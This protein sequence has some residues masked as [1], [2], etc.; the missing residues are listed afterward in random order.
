MA[1]R[2]R[3]RLVCKQWRD[4]IDRRAPEQHARTRVLVFNSEWGSSSRAVVFDLNDGSRR[5]EWTFPCSSRRSR[6]FLVGT[7][8][9][10]LCLHESLTSDK[11]SRFSTT[12][13]VSVTNPITGETTVLPPVPTSWE[14]EQLREQQYSFG[15]HPITGQYKV[16]HIPCLQNQAVIRA[17]Q[18]FTLGDDASSWRNL[19]VLD[20]GVSY[21]GSC[22]VVSVDG[23]TYWLT[24]CSDRVM[25]L[26]LRDERVT[27]FRALA[28]TGP[29]AAYGDAHWMLTNIHAGLGLVLWNAAIGWVKVWVLEDREQQPRWRQIY[30]LTNRGR[31][32][33]DMA[34]HLTYGEY[35]LSPSW[36]FSKTPYFCWVRLYCL[37]VGNLTRCD[38]EGRRLQPS[39]WEELIMRAE[40]SRGG[41]DT[42]PFVET[43]ETLPILSTLR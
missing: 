1:D 31:S 10:L 38:S 4:I 36:E 22:R 6:V 14:P 25:A 42:F 2:R 37:K 5:H 34:P 35:I 27:S 26:D 17:V 18:V 33:I 21:H 40:D 13:S 43:L 15:Y 7:C 41:I 16:V 30:N 23:W 39:E 12:V 32:E 3:L 28:A 8:N 20:T 11:D 9:G 19:P 24:A 29:A